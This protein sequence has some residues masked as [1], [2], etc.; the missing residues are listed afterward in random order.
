MMRFAEVAALSRGFLAG[1][2][3]A[4]AATFASGASASTIEQHEAASPALGRPLPVNVYVPDGVPPATGWPVLY[5]L[6]GHGGNQDSWPQLGKV[7]ATLDRMI[8]DREIAPLLVVMPGAKNSWYVDSAK[9]GG[10]G[11]YETALTRDLVSWVQETYSVRR[12]SGG[13]AIAGLSMGGFGAL[14]LA[15]SHPDLYSST[16]SMSGAIWN[17]VGATEMAM[18][19]DTL[20][21]VQNDVFYQQIDAYTLGTGRILPSV[22][23]HYDGSFGTPFNAARFNEENIFTLV[24][25][26]KKNRQKLPPAYITVG[27]DDG[28]HLWR[29]AIALYQTLKQDGQ[30]AELRVTDGDHLWSVWRLVVS[31]ALR[32]V[33]K[34]W[35]TLEASTTMPGVPLQTASG[36]LDK[37][38]LKANPVSTR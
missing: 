12:D 29:G 26:A 7:Q 33:D 22:G 20:K 17:N 34:N 31:D 18:T 10:P 28:W 13:R 38:T 14:R 37:P 24:E 21:Q 23:D 35:G 8:A 16:V 30:P 27:D 25:D 3:L 32:F 19:P 36:A 4:L 11:D 9:L 5:L 1:T 15:Y 6:H 2:V